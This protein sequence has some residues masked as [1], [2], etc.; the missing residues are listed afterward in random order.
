M[1]KNPSAQDDRARRLAE[2]LRANLRRRKE[3]AREGAATTR[4]NDDHARA[5]FDPTASDQPL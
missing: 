2:Q 5:V 3:Q 1:N 4:S